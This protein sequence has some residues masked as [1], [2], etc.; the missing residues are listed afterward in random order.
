M[1]AIL[2]AVEGGILPPGPE[3]QIEVA[4]RATRPFRR[5]GYVFSLVGTSRCDVRAACSGATLSNASA[6]RSFVPPATTRAG[7][8]QRAVPTTTLNTYRAGCPA[9][10]QARCARCLPL[11]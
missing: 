9:L 11:R 1:A 3:V 2:A 4:S 6:A 8:A 10:R 7:T 5:A